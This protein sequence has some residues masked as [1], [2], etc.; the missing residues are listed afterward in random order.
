MENIQLFYDLFNMIIGLALVYHGTIGLKRNQ[1]KHPKLY[2]FIKDYRIA[3]LVIGFVLTAV[4][5]FKM[6]YH[7]L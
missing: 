7:F 1:E 5:I 2:K 6:T 3:V 4:S